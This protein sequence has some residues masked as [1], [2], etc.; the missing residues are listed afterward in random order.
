[1]FD[2]G[3]HRCDTPPSE[4][5]I[6]RTI[7]WGYNAFVCLWVG[8]DKRTDTS[9]VLDTY[10]A[11]HG[12]IKQHGDYINA[13]KLQ[14]IEATYCDPAGRNKNDQ[15]GR[16]DI[17]TFKGMGIHCRFTL[18]QKLRN[19]ANG[20]QIVRDAM[21]PTSGPP[22]LQFVPNDN[23]REFV[24]AMHNYHNRKVNGVWIDEPK[25]PQDYEHIPDALRYY[26][27]NRQSSGAIGVV[28]YG[29]A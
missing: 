24:T 29:T 19:V 7:D 15:T 12:T 28:G 4:L 11:E 22:K 1:M 20:I 14:R 10:K 26:F 17:D 9:Y 21:E 18:S 27:I 25:D 23:N 3:K 13:H 5:K 6:Y 16:S 8:Y 2:E